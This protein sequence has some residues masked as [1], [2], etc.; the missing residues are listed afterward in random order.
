MEPPAAPRRGGAGLRRVRVHPVDGHGHH[1]RRCLLC[2]HCLGRLRRLRRLR[3][4]PPAHTASAVQPGAATRSSACAAQAFASPLEQ[5][6]VDAIAAAAQSDAGRLLCY[7]EPLELRFVAC[8]RMLAPTSD[9]SIGA[10]APP[11]P[12]RES[13]TLVMAPSSPGPPMERQAVAN[14]AAAIRS[15]RGW[16]EAAPS[17]A[18]VR[19]GDVVALRCVHLDGAPLV[20]QPADEGDEEGVLALGVGV[21]RG[22]AAAAFRVEA[23]IDL[24]G[25]CVRHGDTVLLRVLDGVGG[26]QPPPSLYADPLEDS[27]TRRVRARRGRRG[28]EAHLLEVRHVGPLRAGGWLKPRASDSDVGVV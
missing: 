11:M 25:V 12:P 5:S 23:P 19:Y 3:P 10:R 27:A 26:A 15:G 1:G 4:P 9:G 6:I 22:C 14:E 8:D 24:R 16:R 13:H 28:D 18:P 7:H 17:R 2:H 21:E 20:R